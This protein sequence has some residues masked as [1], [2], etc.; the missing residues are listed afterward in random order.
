MRTMAKT[1]EPTTT[2]TLK[3]SRVIKAPQERVYNAFL[4]PEQVAKWMPPGGYTGRIDKMDARV[5]GAWHGSFTSIDKKETHSFGGKYVEL[6]PYDR[7][8]HTDRFD[9]AGPEMDSEMRV[10]VTFK[11][12]AGGTEL[13]ITQEGIPAIIPLEDAQKGWGQSLDNLARLVEQ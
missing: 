4:D 13:T 6:K 11:K 8:V 2:K 10:T 3:L 5:G 12:A 7:I 9:N 1:S